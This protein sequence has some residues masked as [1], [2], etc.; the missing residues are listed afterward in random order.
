MVRANDFRELIAFK[1]TKVALVSFHGSNCTLLNDLG[2]CQDILNRA[3]L[4]CLFFSSVKRK[5]NYLNLSSLP[6]NN[7]ITNTVSVSLP[8]L[9]SLI[10][11][12]PE[13]I[14]HRLYSLLWIRLVPVVLL[15]DYKKKCTFKMCIICLSIFP[16]SSMRVVAGNIFGIHFCH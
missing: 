5:I 12:E 11:V 8:G 4:P 16:I 15:E 13:V 7:G 1:G 3:L 10:F 14:S 9:F 6:L 2:I